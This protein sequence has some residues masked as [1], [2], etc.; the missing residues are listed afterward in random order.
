MNFNFNTK[1]PANAAVIEMTFGGNYKEIAADGIRHFNMIGLMHREAGP[2][3]ELVDGTREWW[4]EG[5]L[6]RKEVTVH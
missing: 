5:K 2:A 1:A 6:I 4:K 3:V